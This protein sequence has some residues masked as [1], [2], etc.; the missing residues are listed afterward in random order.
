MLIL[1]RLAEQLLVPCGGIRALYYYPAILRPGNT[2]G[3]YGLDISNKYSYPI[4]IYR[5]LIVNILG[6]LLDVSLKLATRA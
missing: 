5:R 2:R 3:I 1:A 6:V 4:I